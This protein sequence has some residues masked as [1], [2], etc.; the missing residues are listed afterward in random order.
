MKCQPLRN[1]L[2][3]WV[4]MCARKLQMLI[5]SNVSNPRKL[6]GRCNGVVMMQGND[7]LGEEK[8]ETILQSCSHSIHSSICRALTQTL[9]SP[10]FCNLSQHLANGTSQMYHSSIWQKIPSFCFPFNLLVRQQ[11]QWLGD[12]SCFR[13]ASCLCSWVGHCTGGWAGNIASC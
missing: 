11:Q 6:N 10:S 2:E 12:N 4:N 3:V 1:N 13:E 7:G 8:E 9:L 5:G